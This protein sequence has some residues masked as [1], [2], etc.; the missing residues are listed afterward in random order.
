VLNLLAA[1]EF[2]MAQKS[3]IMAEKWNFLWSFLHIMLPLLDYAVK[4][5]ND[6]KTYVRGKSPISECELC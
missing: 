5:A 4:R 1:A 3:Q 6:Q 2:N